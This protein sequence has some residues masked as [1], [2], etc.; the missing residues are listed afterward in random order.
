MKDPYTVLGVSQNAT[1]EEIKKA[2]Y[3]LAKKYHPDNYDDSNP[4]KPLA[5]EKMR[6]VNEAYDQIKSMRAG[7]GTGSGSGGA[8]YGSYGGGYSGGS[9]EFQHIRTFI[10]QGRY[11]EADRFLEMTEAS[12]RGAEWYY[13]KGLVLVKKGMVMDGIGY[14]ERACRMDPDNP[15]YRTAYNNLRGAP[16]AGY[17]GQRE[18]HSMGCSMCDM[19]T[20]LM[21]ADCLCD[22]CR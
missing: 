16:F 9:A 13:L 1:D 11:T 14:I 10:M 5:S 20:A 22:C 18:V 6:E 21:C 12:K 2:Y 3:A 17:S 7:G 19:C 4:L 15:E 8:G